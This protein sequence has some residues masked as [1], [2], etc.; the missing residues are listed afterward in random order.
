MS[1]FCRFETLDSVTR[2]GPSRPDESGRKVPGSPG[3]L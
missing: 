2:P 3:G 1:L